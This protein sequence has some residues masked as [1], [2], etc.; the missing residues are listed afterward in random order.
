MSMTGY[1]HVH[2][3]NELR[4]SAHAATRSYEAFATQLALANDCCIAS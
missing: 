3:K 2:R 4:L 1:G